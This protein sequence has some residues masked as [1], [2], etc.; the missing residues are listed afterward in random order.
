MSWWEEKYP[1]LGGW[2]VFGGAETT[3]FW[4]KYRQ[5]AKEIGKVGGFAL[6]GALLGAVL[7]G[8]GKSNIIGGYA[9]LGAW[10]LAK[11]SFQAKNPF[12]IA[13]AASAYGAIKGISSFVGNRFSGR[14]DSYNTIEGLG[15]KGIAPNTRHTLTDFGSG[16]DMLRGLVRASETFEQM[17]AFSRR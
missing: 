15:H 7:P 3:K 1:N 10:Q 13:A 5:A 17:T 2:G 11:Q 14:D 16:W 4:R 6:K 8:E 12:A 9:A